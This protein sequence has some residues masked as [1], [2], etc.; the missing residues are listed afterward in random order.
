MS[1]NKNKITMKKAMMITML[2]AS[3]TASA[4]EWAVDSLYHPTVDTPLLQRLTPTQTSDYVQ[5]GK[6]HQHWFIGFK[7]E[8]LHSWGSLWDAEISSTGRLLRSMRILV[9]G[10]HPMW[11]QEQPSKV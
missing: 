10:S 9:S 5:L 8:R 3:L 4:K 2:A 6:V 1:N 11:V 7:V